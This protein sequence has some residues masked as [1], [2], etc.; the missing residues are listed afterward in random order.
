M[1]F[2]LCLGDM[3]W[4]KSPCRNVTRVLATDGECLALPYCTWMTNCCMI[5]V[6]NFIDVHAADRINWQS[7]NH[8]FAVT[9]WCTDWDWHS[10]RESSD[11]E[12][13]MRY[14]YNEDHRGVLL[15]NG[16]L[17]TSYCFSLA[18]SFEG[19]TKGRI[20]SIVPYP[21]G[22]CNVKHRW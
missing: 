14:R 10:H 17:L 13:I 1:G 19:E 8:S 3:T 4:H 15:N 20:D 2:H 18:E 11:N 12:D 21:R 6:L 5:S 7:S 9:L 22:T 16:A